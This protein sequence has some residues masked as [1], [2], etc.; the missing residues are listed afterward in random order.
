M[1]LKGKAAP[2]LAYR[3]VAFARSRRRAATQA[4][5]WPGRASS[6]PR[7]RF[8]AAGARPACL[9]SP[10]SVRPGVGSRGWPTSSSHAPAVPRSLQGRCL[11]YGEGITFWPVAEVCGSGGSEPDRASPTRGG[12][13]PAA[14]ALIGRARRRAGAVACRGDRL[15]DPG[16][17]EALVARAARRRVRRHPLGRADAPRPDRAH[18]RLVAGCADPAALHGPAGAARGAAGVGRREAERHDG[19]ARAALGTRRRADRQPARRGR[20]RRGCARGSWAAEGNPL[21]VEEM[22]AP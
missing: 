10:S 12:S 14:R 18:R 3:L 11:P 4:R 22:V 5:W 15:G 21:F 9:C 2:V 7:G 6:A 20:G 17:F 8:D 16:C 19:P 13:A 1:E